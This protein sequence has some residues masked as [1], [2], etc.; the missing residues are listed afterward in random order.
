MIRAAILS[1][2]LALPAA[3]GYAPATAA[4]PAGT[5]GSTNMPANGQTARFG[6]TGTMRTTPGNRAAVVELLLRDVEALRPAG[7]HLYVVGLDPD[8]PD[9]IRVTEVWDSRQAHRDSLQ[10][11][12][13]RAAIAEAMP[14]LTGEFTQVEFSAVGGLGLPQ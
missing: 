8:D 12:S 3:S 1:L 10:L 14:M 4:G 13:V 6:L 11:P 5:D 9:L 2:A 7:C